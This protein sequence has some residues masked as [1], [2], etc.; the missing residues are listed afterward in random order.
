LWAVDSSQYDVP[1]EAT[2]GPAV[3]HAYDAT[4][5]GNELWNSSMAANNRDQAGDAVKFAV[6]TIADGKVY[7]GTQAELDVYGLL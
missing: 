6:P 5:L 1:A 7:V 3:V 2:A 4:N